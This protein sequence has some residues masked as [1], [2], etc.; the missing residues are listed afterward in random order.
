MS[1]PKLISNNGP[2]EAHQVNHMTSSATVGVVTAPMKTSFSMTYRAS[3]S[4]S[5]A[6]STIDSWPRNTICTRWNIR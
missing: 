6:V 5:F 1:A 2:H 4:V 3:R